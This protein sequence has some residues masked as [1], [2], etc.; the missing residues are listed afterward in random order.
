MLRKVER[1]ADPPVLLSFTNAL[2]ILCYSSFNW[3]SSFPTSL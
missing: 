3:P 2:V 1:Q